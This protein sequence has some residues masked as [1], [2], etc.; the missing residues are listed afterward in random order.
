MYTFNAAYSTIFDGLSFACTALFDKKWQDKDGEWHDIIGRQDE[1]TET[2]YRLFAPEE[3]I[4]Y[5]FTE[6]YMEEWPEVR[7]QLLKLALNTE[8]KKLA[9][10]NTHFIIDALIKVVPWYEKNGIEKFTK[11]PSSGNCHWTKSARQR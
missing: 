2:H 5:I 3:L 11:F 10:D 6:P 8:K 9:I 4:K 1:K 7:N